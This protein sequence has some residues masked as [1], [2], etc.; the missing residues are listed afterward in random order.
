MNKQIKNFLEFNGRTIL[1]ISNDGTYWVSIKSICEAIGVDHSAQVKRIKRDPILGSKWSKQT[2][3]I[4]D[5]Q[6]R[7]MV[8]V[9][10]KF[11]Y[12]WLFSIQSD[13]PDLIEYKW[14]CYELLYDYFQGSIT[15]RNQILK[16]KSFE[17]LEIERIE[18]ELADDP[19]YSKLI[20]LKKSV[21]KKG[22]E[23]KKLDEEFVQLDLF[24]N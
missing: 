17:Q 21:R 6:P 4:P 1:F 19:K 2:I 9:A 14:K 7:N 22:I 3:Q 15:Y 18:A 23:L 8:C 20:E 12:G 10:E 24:T 13:N 11:I 16:E 5:N